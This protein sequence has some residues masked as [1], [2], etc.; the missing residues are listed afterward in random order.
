VH[1]VAAVLARYPAG[2]ADVGNEM[3]DAP[4]VLR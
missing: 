3:P 1:A 4:V 2:P